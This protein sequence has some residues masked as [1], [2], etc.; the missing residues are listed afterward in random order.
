MIQKE[1]P[2]IELS[3]I[4]VH[5]YSTQIVAFGTVSGYTMGL[6]LG[7]YLGV[8]KG[9]P[10][11]LLGVWLGNTAALTWAGLWTVGVVILIQWSKLKPVTAEGK[12]R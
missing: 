10:R 9:W 8:K 11:P 7:W 4:Y 12:A 5:A 2:T 6:A 1:M 3:T